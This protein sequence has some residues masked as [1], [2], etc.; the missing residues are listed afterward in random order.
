M[1]NCKVIRLCFTKYL[2]L[3][4]KYP[5]CEEHFHSNG[6]IILSPNNFSIYGKLDNLIKGYTA[7]HHDCQVAWFPLEGSDIT[8]GRFTTSYKEIFFLT[9]LPD[10]SIGITFVYSKCRSLKRFCSTFSRYGYFYCVPL[11][12]SSGILSSSV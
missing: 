4:G 9:T 10:G 11:C 7:S 5:L 2:N 12:T 8:N 6:T 1:F 3:L